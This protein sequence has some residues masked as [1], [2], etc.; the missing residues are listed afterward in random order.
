LRAAVTAAAVKAETKCMCWTARTWTQTGPQASRG[1]IMSAWMMHSDD[2]PG[3]DSKY[4]SKKRG[5][6]GVCYCYCCR[7]RS[8]CRCRL[9]SERVRR[10]RHA[11][12]LVPARRVDSDGS[13]HVIPG[14]WDH[15]QWTAIS[16]GE[17]SQDPLFSFTDC[18]SWT[19]DCKHGD[20][21]TDVGRTWTEDGRGKNAVDKAMMIV[22]VSG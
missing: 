18:R 9:G 13:S 11:R 10:G 15:A 5:C 16:A 20:S 1:L 2:G 6:F 19:I 7:C 4:G 21:T 14:R 8:R 12:V 17:P 3:S 22:D